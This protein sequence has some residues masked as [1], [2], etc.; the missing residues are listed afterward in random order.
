MVYNNASIVQKLCTFT[1][2][3]TKIDGTEVDDAEDLD[4]VML[5]YNL[6]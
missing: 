2:C 3:I 5:M 6:L 4:L 1:N